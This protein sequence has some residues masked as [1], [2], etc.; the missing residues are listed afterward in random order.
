MTYFCNLNIFGD[1][2]HCVE[3][4]FYRVVEFV[5]GYYF[6]MERKVAIIKRTLERFTLGNNVQIVTPF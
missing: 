4:K 1:R 6:P 2:W 3:T 5:L